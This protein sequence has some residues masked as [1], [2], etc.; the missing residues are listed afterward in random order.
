MLRVTL[1]GIQI[2]SRVMQ[3]HTCTSTSTQ[4]AYSFGKAVDLILFPG[5]LDPKATPVCALLCLVL[6]CCLDPV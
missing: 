6:Q 5:P 1:L 3:G 2:L 4:S